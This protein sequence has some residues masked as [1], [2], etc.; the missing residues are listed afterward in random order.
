MHR[1]FTKGECHCEGIRKIISPSMDMC[2]SSNFE[3]Y[4]YHLAGDNAMTLA[5]RILAFETAGPLT[6]TG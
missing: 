3:R 2:E 5:S 6:I 1:F 4:L